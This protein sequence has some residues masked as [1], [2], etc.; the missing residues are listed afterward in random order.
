[1]DKVIGIRNGA[2]SVKPRRAR[3]NAAER[4]VHYAPS[5]WIVKEH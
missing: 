3:V 1:M 2:Y 5:D 4:S